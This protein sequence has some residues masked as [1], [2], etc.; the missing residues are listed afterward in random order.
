MYDIIIVGGGVAAF[1]SALFAARRGLKIL[2]IGKDIGGQANFTDLIENYPG[3]PEIGGF[4]LIQSVRRQAEQRGVEFV[5]AEVSKIKPASGGF[6]V[7]AFG[8][9][10]KSKAIILAFGKSP[11]DLKVAGEEELKGKGISYCATCDAP[12][13]KDKVVAVA[14]IGDLGL[15]AALLCAKFAKKVYTLSKND[16]LSGHPALLKAV[17]RKAN[18]ELVPFI[19]IQE[20]VGLQKLEKLRL[21]DLKSGERKELRLEGLFVELGYVVKSE[22]IN[23]LVQLD[24]LGQV[25]VNLDQSTNCPGVYACGDATNQPYKQAVISAGQAATA[26]LSCY[27]YISK[28]AGNTGLTSDWTQIKRVK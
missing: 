9:Q 3:I 8:Q 5:L 1:T 4:E 2:V 7:T 27:D 25:I 23:D 22:F 19:E 18:I 28:L 12:L 6:V 11:M 13:Y 14:G 26:A 24:E 10:Y 16:K 20:V 21:M 17:S 15:D